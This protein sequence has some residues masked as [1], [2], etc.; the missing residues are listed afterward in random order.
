M[1]KMR[2]AAAIHRAAPHVPRTHIDLVLDLIG[3]A[4]REE[5]QSKAGRVKLPRCATFVLVRRAARTV[6]NPRTREPIQKPERTVVQVRP[7]P[8]LLPS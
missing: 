8:A 6:M 4:V 3:P 2:L 5:L 7:H 1:S